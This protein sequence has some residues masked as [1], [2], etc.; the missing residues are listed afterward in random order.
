MPYL[1]WE[2][3]DRQSKMSEITKK[4]ARNHLQ[5]SR[6]SSE[7]NTLQ[8]LGL[9]DQIKSKQSDSPTEVNTSKPERDGVRRPLGRYLIAIANLYAAMDIEPDFRAL[10][11]HLF[12]DPPL[13][14]R[15]T[16]FQSL[17]YSK[18]DGDSRDKRQVIYRGT[19]SGRAL[20]QRACLV[21]VDQLWLYVLDGS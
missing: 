21:M 7:Y 20:A 14:P 4:V 2:S 17:Y 12:H 5:A 8:F 11:D 16:L 13:H 10:R 19:S 18:L 9:I 15:R 6:Y 3:Y 1:H